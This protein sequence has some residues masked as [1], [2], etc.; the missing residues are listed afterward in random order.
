MSLFKFTENNSSIVSKFETTWSSTGAGDFQVIAEFG[1][2]K[3]SLE[4]FELG[5]VPSSSAVFDVEFSH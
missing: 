5:L 4:G 3:F 2:L 1:I